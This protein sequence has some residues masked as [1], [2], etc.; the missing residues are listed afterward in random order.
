L[1]EKP[2]GVAPAGGTPFLIFL[3]HAD[4]MNFA[5]ATVFDLFRLTWRKQKSIILDEIRYQ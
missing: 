5:D 2:K 1:K 3:K 4:S